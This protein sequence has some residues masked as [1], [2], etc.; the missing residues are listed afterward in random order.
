MHDF[1]KGAIA[2]KN[3]TDHEK[4][5]SGFTRK[6][7]RCLA[8][9]AC[10]VG[11]AAVCFGVAGYQ[12]KIHAEGDQVVTRGVITSL[13]QI[14]QTKK[15][16]YD[17]GK[18]AADYTDKDMKLGSKSNPFVI[19]E[20]VP[21]VAYGELGYQ[22]SGCEPVN[23]EEMRF[24]AEDMSS[25]TS[26]NVGSFGESAVQAFF[27]RDELPGNVEHYKDKIKDYTKDYGKKFEGYYEKVED[28]E[29]T[30]VQKEDGTFENAGA[31]KGN[32]IWH[33]INNF[34]KDN[35]KNVDFTNEGK[36]LFKDKEIGERVYTTREH[37][38]K[39]CIVEV[40]R[41]F[42]Y[43]SYDHFLK[44]TL[45]LTDEQAKDYSIVIK[46]ITPKELNEHPDWAKYA[47]LYEFSPKTHYGKTVNLWEN[48]NRLGDTSKVP[49][50]LKGF[51]NTDS[52][53]TKDISWEVALSMYYK[54]NADVNYAAIMMDTE[55]Y[56]VEQL[57]KGKQVTIDILDWNMKP[58]GE[59]YTDKGFNNNVYKLAVMLLSMKHELFEDLYLDKTSPWRVEDGKC[60]AQKGDAQTYW[61]LYT[62][63]PTNEKGEKV[64][65][66]WY[67]YWNTPD[68]WKDYEM[69]G[70]VTTNG[71]RFYINNR[72]FTYNGDNT[73][74]Q[75]YAEP[76]KIDF[77]SK[78]K[79]FLDYMDKEYPDED[80]KPSTSDAIR[81]IL[82]NKSK[83]DNES[84]KGTLKIL[85]IEPC[86][87]SKNGYSLQKTYIRLM[88]PKFR[89]DIEI[90]HMTTAQFI[91]SAE[92]LNST[93]NMIFMGLD[94]GA[95]STKRE[96]V[97]SAN[98]G[99]GGNVDVTYWNDSSMKGKI[100]FHTGD[101]MTGANYTNNGRSRSVEFL[102]SATNAN[103]VVS[104]QKLRFPG[105]DI[106]KIK[107]KEL[108][109]FLNAGY[110]IVAVPYLY[111][112]DTLRIDQ[113]SNI[114][115]FIKQNQSSSDKKTTLLKSSDIS[116]I[117][118]AVKNKNSVEVDFKELP[119][120]YSG[121]TG[122]G[123]TIINPN[124]LKRDNA[125]RSLLT[126]KFNVNDKDNKI[127]SYRIYLDQNQDGKFADDELYFEGNQFRAKDGEQ[128]KTCKLSKLYYGL[129][130]WKI[131]VY[132][133]KANA[134][135]RSV[136]FVKTGCSAAKNMSG[137]GKKEINVLQIMPKNGTYDGKLDLSSN[138]LFSGYYNELE[139]YSIKI[140]T[141]TMEDFQNYFKGTIK[142]TSTKRD[143][144][145]AFTAYDY[146][147][148]LSNE[149][150]DRISKAMTPDQQNLYKYNMYIIGFGD[151]YGQIN[152]DNSNG[153]VDFIKF[154][155]ASGKSVLFTH[156]LTSV[157]NSSSSDFGYS[158]NT[159]LRDTMGMNRYKAISKNVPD[160]Q[161]LSD[162]QNKF[163][164]DTVTDVNGASLQ[165]THGFTYYAMKRLGWTNI[166]A[167]YNKDQKVPYQYMITSSKTGEP[168]CNLGEIAHTGFNNTNDLTTKVQQ[169][170][171][172]QITEYPY[173][174]DE[175]FTI[176]P[177]HGQWYQLN[178]EDP[179]VTV[180]YTLADDGKHITCAQNEENNGTGTAVT[181]GVSP[182]DAANN[183]YIY[184]KG[185]VFYSGVGHS[186]IKEPMEAK[187]FINT[188]IAAYRAS[189]DPPMI[190]LMNPDAEI[191]DVNTMNYQM[192][193]NDEY[194]DDSSTPVSS[195]ESGSVQVEGEGE[196][197]D[198]YIKIRFSPVELNAIST[199]LTCAIYY[200][201]G[202]ITHYVQRIY[203]ADT[204][205]EIECSLKDGKCVYE[206]V[207]NMHEYYF[208]YPKKYLNDWKDGSTTKSA[209]RT[210]NF[211]IK[212]NKAKLP[213]YQTLDMSVRALFRLD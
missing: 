144:S 141:I 76:G 70:N 208:Y 6:F 197:N 98:D 53:N 9:A 182:K 62:F 48:F 29:G 28:G 17:Q 139:D 94:Y 175:S 172:G 207:K 82:G 83:D 131:E 16:M 129:I 198:D 137:L 75:D 115:D 67:N 211:Y 61:T 68:K 171:Q 160:K 87:D 176:S 117:Y 166:P 153:A 47:D 57:T 74:T 126:F 89:G 193:A 146:S 71:N 90:T 136:R 45:K 4:R 143:R 66:D 37:S 24:G 159:L 11:V 42:N 186:E 108:K 79:D 118:S 124:Y 56:S 164:Y 92:D 119:E 180:W 54:V 41:Y 105:N 22:I 84:L 123:K 163:T 212:N 46:T 104:G 206:G 174:I 170:N 167:D 55:C 205:A 199:T 35:Y 188:M 25:V 213:R 189:Y 103:N 112:T 72:M 38:E 2:L 14:P 80:R 168:I 15:D 125:N 173:K 107:Q 36:E 49:E 32:L 77:D 20:V 196:D 110:P 99:K 96:W 18:T 23:I 21:N 122:E 102:Y 65:W 114:C 12:N 185:N 44:D 58:S 203:D 121:E 13:G 93:Y 154:F 7:K 155:I 43:V 151:T 192:T 177:T 169:S 88:I 60:L 134:K 142:D 145:K 85:D 40:P 19:L 147:K 51:E 111:D 27:F 91:G 202:G 184:S 120:K 204:N 86:Y 162:Y 101:K 150:Y 64:S 158:A 200:E 30:F 152:I 165:Q 63:C 116:G 209:R 95:Y 1:K 132:E 187:L 109:D 178:M 181:Y 97:A 195:S 149:D 210:I 183:Y 50:G 194:N 26:M 191:T 69:A 128:K 135:D 106:T 8:S 10:V 133:V 138:A 52:D 3:R 140:K 161:K 34:E 130:Q 148:D 31:G 33:T 78:F 127:Y 59:T 201:D 5:K 81:Y 73:I 100:Y 113:H 39:D 157:H 190:E 179:E 156:D